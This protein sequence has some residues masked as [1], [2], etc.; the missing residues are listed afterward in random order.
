MRF[1]YVAHP[2]RTKVAPAVALAVGIVV[3]ADNQYMAAGGRLIEALTTVPARYRDRIFAN[4]DSLLSMGEIPG[5]P[6]DERWA[7]LKR[8]ATIPGRSGFAFSLGFVNHTCRGDPANRI[9]MPDFHQVWAFGLCVG[10]ADKYIVTSGSPGEVSVV[11][12]ENRA[13]PMIVAGANEDRRHHLRGVAKHLKSSPLTVEAAF[14]P[15]ADGEPP[16]SLQWQ[17]SRLKDTVHFCSREDAPFLQLAAIG[18]WSYQRLVER[19]PIGKEMVEV[20][21]GETAPDPAVF[22]NFG[23]GIFTV[24]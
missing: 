23:S 9:A 18:A 15:A 24:E 13:Q 20:F 19:Q 3:D 5:W 22:A 7:L 8:L 16:K 21:T 4:P 2:Q 6:R 17:I 1:I 14:P 12:A 10:A 11:V